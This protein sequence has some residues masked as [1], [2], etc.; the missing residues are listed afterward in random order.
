MDE[1]L[2]LDNNN[3]LRELVDCGTSARL[4]LSTWK[5]ELVFS[6]VDRLAGSHRCIALDA[7]KG[8]RVSRWWWWLFGILH[9]VKCID[10]KGSIKGNHLIERPIISEGVYR[11]SWKLSVCLFEV[12][13][14]LILLE[15]RKKD[16]WC[17]SLCRSSF[18][19]ERERER[20]KFLL[21]VFSHRRW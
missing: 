13:K 18:K 3:G 19:L 14:Y 15:R 4:E 7:G 20:E 11:K 9:G 10:N 5:H 2:V 21:I 8:R 17:M 12:V 16:G 1:I 6:L